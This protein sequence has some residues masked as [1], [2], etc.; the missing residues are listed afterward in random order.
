MDTDTQ[1]KP[2]DPRR[3]EAHPERI[4][5]GD[6]VFERNDVRA[7]NLG[8]SEKSLNGDDAEGAPY[9]YFG[10]VKY[11]PVKRHDAHILSRIKTSKPEPP[12]HGRRR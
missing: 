12:K 11:R 5:V 6:E 9:I 3:R 10:K 8:R 4:T 2:L 7:R 1:P